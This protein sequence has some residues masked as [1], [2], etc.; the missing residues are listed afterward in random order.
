MRILISI[1]LIALFITNKMV[2]QT[3]TISNGA[4]VIFEETTH[5]YGTLPYGGDGTFKYIFTNNGKTP[6]IITNCVK[7]CGCTDVQWTREPVLPGQKGSVKVTYNTRIIGHFSKGVDVYSNS[8]TP[9]INLR[10]KGMVDEPHEQPNADSINNDGA[11]AISFEKSIFDLG[12][13]PFNSHEVYKFTFANTGKEPLKVVNCVKGERIVSIEGSRQ[14]VL[15]GQKSILTVTFNT[16]IEGNFNTRII[17][18]SNAKMPKVI[19]IKGTVGDSKGTSS[20][21]PPL[22][23]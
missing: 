15:P 18:Y 16:Q 7:G 10:L 8:K 11:P 1:L 13:I 22:V 20:I 2:A 23:K 3:D 17:V 4:E 12:N 14:T 19:H 5:D 21:G 6:L 9:K